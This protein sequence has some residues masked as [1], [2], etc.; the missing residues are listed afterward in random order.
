MADPPE[1]L[2]RR[3]LAAY[4]GG[5]DA[6][7]LVE[8]PRVSAGTREIV[9][10]FCRRTDGGQLLLERGETL[11]IVASERHA[12]RRLDERLLALGHQVLEFQR[13]AVASWG[14]LPLEDDGAWERRDDAIDR[15]AWRL[16]RSLARTSRDDPTEEVAAVATAWTIARSL[17]RIADHAVTLGEVG[18]RLADGGPAGVPLRELRQFH[19][20][21]MRH[22]E[23]V[24]RT[25]DAPRANDLLDVGEAL[26]TG[27]RA[28][29]E[30]LLPDLSER[31][32]APATAAAVARAFEAISRTVAYGQDIAQAFLDRALRAAPATQGGERSS[33]TA[34]VAS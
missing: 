29:S 9:R 23:E 15:E 12:P 25:P 22:L 19:A 27:G 6:L 34:P 21:A 8:R 32:M 31:A 3:L 24:L 16:E 4:L 5:A 14:S 18:P 30:T 20:Q 7:E 13:E 33:R 17:E 1:H 2:F 26:L 10:E 28:L 11:E